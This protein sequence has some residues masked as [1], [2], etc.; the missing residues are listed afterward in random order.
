MKGKA[1]ELVVNTRFG[2]ICQPLPFDTIAEAERFARTTEYGFHFRIYADNKVVR[3]G[4][5]R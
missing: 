5:C 2:R 4:F 1:C 3:S